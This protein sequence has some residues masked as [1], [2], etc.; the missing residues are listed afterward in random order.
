MYKHM[1]NNLSKRKQERLKE[2]KLKKDAILSTTLCRRL[3]P[4]QHD[5]VVARTWK[6]LPVWE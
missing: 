6:E 5:A 1:P 3:V 2:D 4:F